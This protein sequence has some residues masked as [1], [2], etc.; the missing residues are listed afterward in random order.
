M[1]DMVESRYLN[2]LTAKWLFYILRYR[3]QL[4]LLL[5]LYLSIPPVP[6]AA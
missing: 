5:A 2:Q 6:L 4:V 1:R 3:N